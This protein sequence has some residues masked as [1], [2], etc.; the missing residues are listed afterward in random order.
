LS[1]KFYDTNSNQSFD[2]RL[3]LHDDVICRHDIP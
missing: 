3:S 2:L 1:A